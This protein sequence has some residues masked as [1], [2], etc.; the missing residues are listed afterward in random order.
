MPSLRGLGLQH[1]ILE[2]GWGELGGG[3]K[4]DMNLQCITVYLPG[5]KPAL[6][7]W[8]L[9]F[10]PVSLSGENIPISRTEDK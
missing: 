2:M 8:S 1:T 9:I 7:D 5:S 4:K 10:L 3:G 6:D